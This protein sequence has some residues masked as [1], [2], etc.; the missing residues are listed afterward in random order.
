MG[1]E[2]RRGAHFGNE[3]APFFRRLPRSSRRPSV[4]DVNSAKVAGARGLD[5]V[6]Q[7][8]RPGI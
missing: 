3:L 1:A 2:W 7:R 6:R 4:R 8:E 5:R